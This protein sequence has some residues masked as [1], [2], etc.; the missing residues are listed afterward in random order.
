MIASSPFQRVA[1]KHFPSVSFNRV[2]AELRIIPPTL[3]IWKN[4]L[5][6]P[7]KLSLIWLAGGGSHVNFLGRSV[8]DTANE[9]IL[10]AFHSWKTNKALSLTKFGKIGLLKSMCSFLIFQIHQLTGTPSLREL[11]ETLDQ[12]HSLNP[13]NL[14]AFVIALGKRFQMALEMAQWTN[15]WLTD[16]FS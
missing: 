6:K 1:R 10:D 3:A 7:S 12:I 15:R 13:S 9:G 11:A 16:S 5:S 4:G 14:V 8:F 2:H